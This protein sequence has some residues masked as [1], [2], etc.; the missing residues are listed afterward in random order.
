MNYKLLQIIRH[1]AVLII[2]TFSISSLYAQTY[3]YPSFVMAEA[4]VDNSS[5]AIDANMSS[6]AEIKANPGAL[7]GVGSYDGHLELQ[8]PSLVPANTTT[9]I[10]VSMDDPIL[11]SMLGG[12]LG[13]VLANV[14]GFALTGSQEF[15]VHVKNGGTTSLYG[16]STNPADFGTE[17]LNIVVNRYD[18]TFIA[19][20]PNLP[21]DRI[22]IT[23]H[24]GASLVGL[25][26]DKIFRVYDA[27]YVTNPPLCGD[28]GFTSFNAGGVN[29][30]LLEIAGSGATDIHKAIDTDKSSFS[31]LSLG[32]LNI[33]AW[34]EQKVYF[35]GLST[36]TDVFGVKF[37]IDES[38]SVLGLMNNITLR[39][40]NGANT[41]YTTPLINVMN[42]SAMDSLVN[43]NAITVYIT[44][45][46]PVDRI[47]FRFT[48]MLGVNLNQYIELNEIF[49]VPVAPTMNI[50]T[51]NST[52]CMGSQ[53][54]L[55]ADAADPNWM[56]NWYDD[57]ASTT[58]IGTTNSGSPFTT[59]AIYNDST[60]YITT[61][62]PGCTDQTQKVP[63][64]ITVMPAPSASDLS[65]LVNPAGYCESTPA[66]IT[67]S[68]TIGNQFLWFLD[69][70][71]T[72]VITDGMTIGGIT[73]AIDAQGNL[74]ISGLDDT[75][76]P[77]TYYSAVIDSVTGCSNLPGDF[78]S[79][80]VIINV[81]SA[82]TTTDTIQYFC[83]LDNPTT[84]N[85]VIAGTSI[86]WYDAAN[87]G[88]I[89]Q[90]GTALI[91]GATYYA[92]QT[93]V[94]CESSERVA[95]TIYIDD[96]PTPTTNQ[97][98]QFFCPSQ[99]PTIEDL[100]TNES[101]VIWY[102]SATGGTQILG[103][104]SLV[105][106]STYYAALV[107]P[108]CESINRLEIMVTIDEN[109]ANLIGQTTNV[110]TNDT[111][112]YETAAGMTNYIWNIQGGTI[113]AG[114]SST[115]NTV[116]VSWQSSITPSISVSFE[117]LS[118]CQVSMLDALG[119]SV[120]SCS[121]LTISKTVDNETP[122]VGSI[123]T[124]TI[125]V[126]NQGQSDFNNLLVSESLPSG[127]EYISHTTTN[128]TYNVTSG[129][130]NIPLLVMNASANLY[131]KVKVLSS[132]DYLN[133]ARI[134]SIDHD[135]LNNSAEASAEPNCLTVYNE[136][137]PNGDGINDFL[138]IDCI[139]NYP[140]NSIS[141][142]NRY[143]NVIY[144]VDSYNNE[145]DGVANVS[146]AIGKGE[147]VPTGTYFYILK[148]DE[149]DFE[150]N[151]WVYI[152]R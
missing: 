90:P 36:A 108:N 75:N 147:I 37:R 57:S 9:F 15:S 138:I 95:I 78:T 52:V 121:D 4:H 1:L 105:N 60:L 17:Y 77:Y 40:Q 56:I 53:A 142:F 49:K 110:C 96:L 99:N 28:P 141:I 62:K 35:E 148:V 11:N 5:L 87:G 115:N 113:I 58:P 139:E 51:S 38:L 88:T 72:Q 81:E 116:T 124:F 24:A 66:L 93:G 79:A 112:T 107:S 70:N 84:N 25:N 97:S 119:I 106:G 10:K 133:V 150:T 85:I 152:V 23:N 146:G 131:V 136:I 41:V 22:R 114:G 31:E 33:P 137:S 111:I 82:P 73:F 76:S 63:V 12:N 43:G 149:N 130:W 80:D 134:L 94:H 123:V 117:T 55:V 118:G 7:L 64:Q 42:A 19:V 91:N 104:T 54:S 32:V 129:D 68:S 20:T 39:A 8:F 21:Y 120:I 61:F 145:W 18:E 101:S 13:G 98:T 48:A 144:N 103:G 132:G 6:F 83:T 92:S 86:T 44:P 128:G 69:V 122:F 151:G 3:V 100:I 50:L 2:F 47:I 125:S 29:I 126:Q 67:P 30:D 71:G 34:I 14:T 135:L 27:Y 109:G 89:I 74:T 45:G 143:G 65:L 16:S 102:N 127:Y 140:N 46:A 59:G 26:T